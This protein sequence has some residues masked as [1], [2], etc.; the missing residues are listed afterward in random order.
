MPLSSRLP[1]SRRHRC[2][3]RRNS[4]RHIN[5]SPLPPLSQNIYASF[6][7]TDLVLRFFAGTYK[8]MPLPSALA[9]DG[10]DYFPGTFHQFGAVGIHAKQHVRPPSPQL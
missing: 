6:Q 9:H 1:H 10:A 4:G 3:I 5:N 7:H 2:L 8:P